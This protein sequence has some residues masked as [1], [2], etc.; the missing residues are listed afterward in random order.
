MRNSLVVLTVALLLG[1]PGWIA[2]VLAATTDQASA[3]EFAQKAVVRV[4]DYDQGNRESLMDAQDDFTP[5]G[6]REFMKWL[7]GYLDEK[8]AP[9]GSSHFTPTGDPVVKRQENGVT[10]L[11]IPGVLKQESKNARGG[12]FRTTYRAT[13]EVQVGGN[14]LK[15]EHLKTT[16]CGGASTVASC[17]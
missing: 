9:L 10:A 17:R 14:P 3:L 2:C 4:L 5:E 7:N 11:E 16:T 12:I 15:I 8:G 1:S 13:I 6:W